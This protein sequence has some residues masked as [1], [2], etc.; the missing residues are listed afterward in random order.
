MTDKRVKKTFYVDAELVKKIKIKSAV[1]EATETETV[2]H[3]LEN[4]F[5]AEGKG[6]T[7]KKEIK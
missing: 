4:Y 3:I 5:N 1:D 6:Y 2:N 7:L